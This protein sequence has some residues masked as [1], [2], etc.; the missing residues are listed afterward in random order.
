MDINQQLQPIVAGLIDNLKVSIEQELQAKITDEVIKKIAGAELDTVVDSLVKKQIGDRLDKFNFADTSREQLTA[1]ITKITSDVNKTVIDKANVQIT[2]EI[3]KQLATI[4]LN[5]IVNEIVK[6][7]LLELIKLH[8]FPE[9]SIA[10][11]AINFQ[12]LSLSGDIINGGIIRNF[13]SA[14]IEDR[15]SFVQLTLMDH[16]CAFEGPVFAPSAKITGDLTVDGTLAL[17]GT[18][19]ESSPGFA[20]LVD[21]AGSAVVGK[22]DAHLFTGFSDIVFGRIQET[23]IDLDKITQ[24]GKEIV[25]GPQLGYHIVDSNL[26]RVGVVRDL[27]TSGEN[28]LSETLYV[29]QRRVG[30]NTMDPSAVFAVWDEE[31]ELIVAKRKTDVAY[32][33]T[34]RKQQLIL[35]S[36]GK[37]NVVLDT[38]GSAKIENLVVGRVAMTSATAV[39]N[40]AGEMAQIV[41]NELPAP[42]S[43]IGWVC[44]G[45]SR[46]AKFGMIE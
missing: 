24:G 37:E 29:T 40:Y 8:N 1:Q 22:L 18:V 23:G 36:N 6:S 26:Q 27:Q 31:V 38:D 34:P 14:G 32:I 41:Y 30:V 42:G 39:P 15:A 19:L 45:G 13:G 25:K 21:A 12:G 28:L 46:W 10:H 9:R 3:K 44:I 43:P 16:A 33:A 7:K 20:Q 4:D 2:Q 5:L 11:T 17:N 35:G